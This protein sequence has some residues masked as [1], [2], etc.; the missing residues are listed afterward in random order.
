MEIILTQDIAKLGFTNDI[1]VVKDGYA[2]NYLIP[3]GLAK[4]ATI[5]AK[6][7]MAENLKQRAHKENQIRKE[8]D[9]LAA[10]IEAIELTIGAK[11]GTSGKIFG[12][13]NAMQISDALKAQANILVDRKK[14]DV[15]GENIKEV[16]NYTAF[17][18]IHREVK[19]TIKFSVIAE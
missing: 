12:S 1:I 15:K 13:V 3:K 19:A 5:S 14:I 4:Q 2:R 10:A 6:K 16:G 7:V 18:N 8:A 11:V 17:V 9:A